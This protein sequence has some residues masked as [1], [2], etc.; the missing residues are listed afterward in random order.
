MDRL[1]QVVSVCPEQS[2]TGKGT[3]LRWVLLG[4]PSALLL[5]LVVYL[6]RPEA[7][8]EVFV[9]R[10][11]AD[12]SAP[13]DPDPLNALEMSLK[14]Y[15]RE[16]KGYD[17]ILYKQERIDGYLHKP[18]EIQVHFKEKPFSVF[19]RWLRG[20]RRAK[21]ALYVAGQNGGQML[22]RPTGLILSRFVVSR[23][24]EGSDAH[25][26][27]RYSIKEFGIKKSTE[28][29]LAAWKRARAKKTLHLEYLKI[30]TLKKLG[31]RPCYKYQAT[32]DQPEAG[33]TR[34]TI[35]IDKQTWLQVGS[36]LELDGKLIA[37][38]FFHDIHLNPSFNPDTFTREAL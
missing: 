12:N 13:I 36:V 24:P 17:A 23:D 22:V 27:G 28:R 34:L 1:T 16:V 37:S 32:Y 2:G 5:A 21:T 26:A 14:R 25:Q 9:S 15:D 18:E 11:V 30:Q 8:P 4:L 6:S 19:L 10:P 20:E 7:E 29:T 33:I 38:Y 31:N 35:Y 3:A